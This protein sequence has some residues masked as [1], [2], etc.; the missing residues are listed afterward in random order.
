MA[1]ADCA[2]EFEC[3]VAIAAAGGASHGKQLV[4]HA[5]H[6]AYD[7]DGVFRQAITNDGAA[8]GRAAF[9]VL[10]QITRELF[11][12]SDEEERR[13]EIRS[14]GGLVVLDRPQLGVER[15][16]AVEVVAAGFGED[17]DGGAGEAA[18]LGP[19]AQRHHPHFLDGV[20]VDVD[21]RPEGPGAGVGGVDAVDE[22][23]V[24]VR[25]ARVGGGTLELRGPGGRARP[26]GH[27]RRGQGQVVEGIAAR[28]QL[29][30]EVAV[31][32]RFDGRR[33]GVDDR[34]AADHDRLLEGAHRQRQ[35]ERRDRAGP[36]VYAVARHRLEPGH[37][38]RE[39]VP[40]GGQV[41]E[42]VRS[43]R[44]RS[45]RSRG[46]DERGARDLH[47]RPG[48]RQLVLAE[49]GAGQLP[50]LHGLREEASHA[51]AHE[52]EGRTDRSQGGSSQLHGVL[53]L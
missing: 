11:S 18:V 37:R 20:V 53:L 35:V 52:E 33:L 21:E 27:A 17:V 23:D 48:Q 51:S 12:L 14:G 42:D 7:N 5:R 19:G 13:P 46:G 47:R 30:D 26:F 34:A 15:R 31:E 25:G 39:L 50:L 38:R 10:L 2:R 32:P 16:A 9:P 8:H 41:E 40:A 29:L 36:D 43:L 45:G 28:R 24:L 44:R 1:L 4:G 3:F 6:G 22:E 49:H